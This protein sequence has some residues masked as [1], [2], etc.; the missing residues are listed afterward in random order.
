[1]MDL[2][3]LIEKHEEEFTSFTGL[4]K[5][6]KEV[7]ELK[8]FELNIK[9]VWNKLYEYWPLGSEFLSENRKDLATFLTLAYAT[10]GI[11]LKKRTEFMELNTSNIQNIKKLIKELDNKKYKNFRNRMMQIGQNLKALRKEVVANEQA[12]EMQQNYF[13]SVLPIFYSLKER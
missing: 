13:P 5:F 2:Q 4:D 8:S 7:L 10:Q 1:M 6:K 12:Y 3:E 9:E 11:K